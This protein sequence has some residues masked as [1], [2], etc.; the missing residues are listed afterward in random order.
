MSILHLKKLMMISKTSLYRYIRYG[1]KRSRLIFFFFFSV[2]LR[3]RQQPV[4]YSPLYLKQNTALKVSDWKILSEKKY[5][6][7]L[8]SRRKVYGGCLWLLLVEGRVAL[9]QE[10]W[11]HR[12]QVTELGYAKVKL[13]YCNILPIV[14]T[15][16]I[17]GNCIAFR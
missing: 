13:I 16:V 10:L 14:K 2:C 1:Y 17:V 4:I 12:N 7:G 15:S 11:I 9:I 8:F 6:K 3:L 5:L